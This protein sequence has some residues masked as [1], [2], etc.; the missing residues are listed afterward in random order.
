MCLLHVVLQGIV[1]VVRLLLSLTNMSSTLT[2][3][4]PASGAY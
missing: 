2:D 4:M 1:T 3:D